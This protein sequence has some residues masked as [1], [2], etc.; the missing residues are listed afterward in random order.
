MLKCK[1]FPFH[2]KPASLSLTSSFLNEV[3]V[4]FEQT[5]N[6]LSLHLFKL[7]KPVPPKDVF[8]NVLNWHFVNHRTYRHPE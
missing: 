1:L 8:I 7:A 5:T 3:F 4:A 2:S 6:V